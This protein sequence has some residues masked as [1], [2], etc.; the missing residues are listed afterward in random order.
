MSGRRR[1]VCLL[2][3]ACLL[4]GALCLTRIGGQQDGEDQVV[5]TI[6]HQQTII[7][8]RRTAAGELTRCDTVEVK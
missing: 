5:T 2:W 8:M 1:F 7:T 3:L 4:T 6:H